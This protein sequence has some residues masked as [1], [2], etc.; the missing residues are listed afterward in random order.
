MTAA[1]PIDALKTLALPGRAVID[2]ALVEAASGMTFHNVSPRDGT[3]LNQVAACQGEDV[4]RAVAS[5]RAAFEDG[6]WRDQGPRAKKAVL[7]RLAELM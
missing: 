7:F 6:R 4:D 2:G 1:S 5:A 3:V